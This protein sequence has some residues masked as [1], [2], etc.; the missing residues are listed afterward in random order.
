MEPKD[1]ALT[2]APEVWAAFAEVQRIAASGQ[3]LMTAR[4]AEAR[5]WERERYASAAD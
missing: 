3:V 2:F 1:V 5:E 4:A